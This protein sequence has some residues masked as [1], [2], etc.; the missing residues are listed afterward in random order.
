V[1]STTLKPCHAQAGGFNLHTGL[2]VRAGQRDP[3]ERLRRYALQ[4][5]A[6]Q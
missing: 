1:T 3:S 6:N 2:L 4:P 5:G